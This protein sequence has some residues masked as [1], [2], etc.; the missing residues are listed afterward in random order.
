MRQNSSASR[1]ITTIILSVVVFSSAASLATNVTYAEALHSGPRELNAFLQSSASAGHDELQSMREK[2]DALARQQRFT[3]ARQLLERACGEGDMESCNQLAIFYEG[4]EGTE[5]NPG[6]AL[7]PFKQACDGRSANACANLASRFLNGING[8][9]KDPGQSAVWAQKACDYG[10]VRY[11]P[12]VQ[13]RIYCA[14]LVNLYRS[15]Y[16]A[17]QDIPKARAVLDRAC[18]D[19]LSQACG[20]L[21]EHR[22]A[23]GD[24]NAQAQANQPGPQ[25]ASDSVA[26]GGSPTPPEGQSATGNY[27]TLTADQMRDLVISS[28]DI[29]LMMRLLQ[30]RDHPEQLSTAL[31]LGASTNLKFFIQLNNCNNLQINREINN[32]FDY[33]AMAAYYKARAPQILAELPTAISY[34]T[35]VAVGEYKPELQ[36]F[37]VKFQDKAIPVTSTGF[38]RGCPAVSGTPA[39][40]RENYAVVPF[41]VSRIPMSEEDAR[42]YLNNLPNP[43]LRTIALRFDMEVS[44]NS[45]ACKDLPSSFVQSLSHP[46]TMGDFKEALADEITMLQ[47]TGVQCVYFGPLAG[48]VGW[49]MREGGEI[50]AS[51]DPNPARGNDGFLYRKAMTMQEYREVD[52]YGNAGEFPFAMSAF[53]ERSIAGSRL[54]MEDYAKEQEF[55]VNAVKLCS[56]LT[57]EM[58][59]KGWEN[60]Q[61]HPDVLGQ[62]YAVC[63]AITN[64]TKAVRPYDPARERAIIL[65]IGL[66]SAGT[67]ALVS[68]DRLQG[69]Y[70]AAAPELE[71]LNYFVSDDNE[72]PVSAGSGE[73]LDAEHNRIWTLSGGQ[74]QESYENP[75]AAGYC[76]ALR[77]GGSPHWRL[78]TFADLQTIQDPRALQALPGG[79]TLRIPGETIWTE[80]DTGSFSP[81]RQVLMAKD[82]AGRLIWSPLSGERNVVRVLCVRSYRWWLAGHA[83]AATSSTS[84]QPGG[85][86]PGGPSGAAAAADTE[87]PSCRE[88][89]VTA[90]GFGQVVAVQV[91]FVNDSDFERKLYRIDGMG[92]KHSSGS[93][94]PHSTSR[95]IN[96]L[97]GQVWLV[98]DQN[99][100]CMMKF[101]A[102]SSQTISLEK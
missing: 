41:S 70:I 4:G 94:N 87:D 8:G 61:F 32:E 44:P 9:A 72:T 100:K 13:L 3:E 6:R 39:G 65:N 81:G 43:A 11:A 78:P 30:I 26:A 25:P 1:W 67:S 88:K 10:A 54:R 34:W 58:R 95:P 5:R 76:E 20:A 59:R 42:Q 33:P 86:S 38:P 53:L 101:R 19:G 71:V 7:A 57:S 36:G 73:W 99:K 24:S 55:I 66:S 64:V 40:G 15:G 22:P 48:K 49:A 46:P 27:P 29:G 98:E 37:A 23:N 2:A 63:N 28:H 31:A 14:S 83:V 21:P 60:R 84:P 12:Y 93:V 74:R 56:S 85:G 77:T 80:G 90:V 16:V 91:Q 17:E 50:Q 47:G 35:I 89:M 102:E 68:F 96:G 52:T 92:F 18:K 62:Q 45:V 69:E 75:D 82:A 97:A 51:F 79:F